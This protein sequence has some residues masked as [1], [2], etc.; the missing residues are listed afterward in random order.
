MWNNGRNGESTDPMGQEIIIRSTTIAM[1]KIHWITEDSPLFY[2]M[3]KMDSEFDKSEERMFGAH[4]ASR[5]W[6]LLFVTVRACPVDTCSPG[7]ACWM[8]P[9]CL[10]WSRSGTAAAT[11]NKAKKADI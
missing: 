9:G 7:C 4:P 11:P 8:L 3:V 1:L 10:L 2:S 6:P 5:R